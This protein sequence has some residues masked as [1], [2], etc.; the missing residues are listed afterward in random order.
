ML[1]I[2]VIG[3]LLIAQSTFWE[4]ARMRPD[5]NFLV[6][7]WAMRGSE[8]V[9]GSI[10]AAIGLALVA[11]LLVVSQ[12]FAE[13]P[14]GS[15]LVA[16]GLGVIAVL[17]VIVFADREL[18]VT[19][20]FIVQALLAVVSTIVLYRIFSA[21]IGDDR[22]AGVTP[23]AGL[24][25]S[26]IVSFLVAFVALSGVSVDAA[27]G[28]AFGML[29]LPMLALALS[30]E[31][32]EL[33]ANRMLVMLSLAAILALGLQAGAIRQTLID[34]QA[35]GD[36]GAPADYQD[37]QITSGYFWAQ[38]GALMVFVS[39]VAT[40]AKRRDHIL[41]VRRAR[42]QREAAE[43]SAREIQEALEAAGLGGTTV[44][45]PAAPA[46]SGSGSAE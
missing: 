7:P 17:I 31:P 3:G 18:T 44:A 41:N 29:V 35:A 5:F 12:K 10:S 38:I 26:A 40:W 24:A 39:A 20:N 2:G 30:G 45:A 8:M 4:Y 34:A 27:P 33:A 28:L 23:I 13:H 6:E 37:S 46:G 9:H 21:V 16:T 32:R 15:A 42:R 1:W 36:F 19:F 14:A 25:G 11:A 22:M 43:A